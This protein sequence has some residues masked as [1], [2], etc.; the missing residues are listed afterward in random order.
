[1]FS[2]ICIVAVVLGGLIQKPGDI[3]GGRPPIIPHSEL[4]TYPDGYLPWRSGPC[5]LSS[6][7]GYWKPCQEQGSEVKPLNY[8]R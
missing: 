2:L 4:T 1:M 6:M 3:G 8:S 7:E 5:R